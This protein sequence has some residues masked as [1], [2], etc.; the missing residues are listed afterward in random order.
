M[1]SKPDDNWKN[2]RWGV[3]GSLKGFNAEAQEIKFEGVGVVER[4]S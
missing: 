2:I 4:L 3:S 1:W